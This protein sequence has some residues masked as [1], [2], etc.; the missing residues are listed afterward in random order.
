[1]GTLRADDGLSVDQPGHIELLR[2]GVVE[3]EEVSNELAYARQ[4]DAFAAAVESML[5]LPPR[6]KKAGA[7]NSCSTPLIAA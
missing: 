6:Q 7:T 2:N 1:V 3:T 4:A 5:H